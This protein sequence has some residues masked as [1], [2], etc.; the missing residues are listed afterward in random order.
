M[1]YRHVCEIGRVEGENAR[2]FG[3]KG[4][5]LNKLS[6]A[7]FAVPKAWCVTAD[8]YYTFLVESGLRDW[9]E[10]FSEVTEDVCLE[11]Q[12]RIVNSPLSETLRD[13][14][15]SAYDCLGRGQVAVR[16]SG[17]REDGAERSYAGQHDT[18]LYVQGDDALCN[19]VKGCWASLWSARARVYRDRCGDSGAVDDGI[20]VVIQSMIDADVAGVVFTA[21]PVSGNSERFVIEACWGVGEGVVTGQVTT[22][23]YVID[24]ARQVVREANIRSKQ[25]MYGH[26][27]NGGAELREVPTA[28]IDAP[29]L[30]DAQALELA[31]EA[32]RIRK[33]YGCEMDVEWAWMEDKLWILQARPITLVAPSSRK[34][35]YADS[36]ET[37]ESV[38]ENAMFSRMD[39][40]EIVTG[41]MSPLGL[42]FCRFYQH[43]IHGPAIK[44]IGLLDIGDPAH[45]MGYI[46]G[47]VYLNISSS[48]RLLTQCPPT[49]DPV[50]F[51]ERHATDEV[52][53]TRYRNPYGAAVRGLAYLKSSLYWLGVQGYNMVSAR[54]TVRRIVE[55][56][57]KETE[58]FLKLDLQSMTLPQLNA[59]LMRIDQNFLVGC[60]AYMPFFI[61]SFA[62]YDALSDLCERWLDQKGTGLQN[63]IKASMN[64]LRTIEITRG[65]RDLAEHVRNSSSLRRIF[66]SVSAEELPDALKRDSKG[67]LF[68]EGPFARFLFEFGSRGRQEFDLSI[69]RWHDDPVYLL[70]IIRM[71]LLNEIN[72]E[73]RLV[74][75]GDERAEET[76]RCLS[77]LPLKARMAFRFVISAY[78]RTAERREATR[79]TFIAETW[80]YRKIIMEVLQRLSEHGLV[81]VDDLPY[82]DFNEFRAY[83]AGEKSAEQ[84]LS[85]ALIEHNRREHM[86]NQRMKEPPMSIIGG[87]MPEY[88]EGAGEGAAEGEVLDGL[89]ASPGVVV[90]RTRVVTDL[91]RQAEELQK[92]EIL[93]TKYTDASWTPLFLLAAGVITDIGSTLSHSSIVSREFGIPAVVNVKN[94]TQKIKTGDLV[95]LDGNSGVIRVTEQSSVAQDELSARPKK[96][97]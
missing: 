18:F 7:G 77:G 38:R 62:L 83:I 94:A 24:S 43:N 30:T 89:A 73:S 1:D 3:G 78:G 90:A 16:S 67:K 32:D 33:H 4:D 52:D 92:G 59:E 50:T 85:P 40:G 74:K 10:S 80:F 79:P 13:E 11:L 14:I 29:S 91:D 68:W 72:L 37:T 53:L 19:A 36:E 55:L 42:S 31:R 49:R 6:S 65:L 88:N 26:A 70:K 93:V 51:T 45:S 5:G 84:A 76:R 69:P 20:V 23:T 58:R 64:N 17:L 97:G 57:Q 28:A 63:R 95:Y 54:R 81:S 71:Y 39:T 15:V 46:L 21:D 9:L 25:W 34:R 61:Q 75:V 8:A 60:K 56:R 66:Q 12:A 2:C 48:A 22:D 87:H 35:L 44:R 86:L 82:V 47:H 96:V 27:V 41:L